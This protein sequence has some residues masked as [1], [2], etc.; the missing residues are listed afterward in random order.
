MTFYEE[1]APY[2]KQIFPLQKSQVAFVKRTFKQ[3]GETKLLEVGCGIGLLS[4]ALVSTQVKVAAFDLDEGMI[5]EAIKTIK[6]QVVPSEYLE[7]S[8]LNMLDIGKT[9]GNAAF[10]G[11]LCFGNTL[12]HLQSQENVLSFLKQAREVLKPYG[13]LLFQILN[14]ER[15]LNQKITTLPLIESDLISFERYYFYPSHSDTIDFKTILT[16]KKDNQKIEHTIPLLAL[17]RIDVETLLIQSGF[18]KYSFYGSYEMDP[19]TLD[20]DSLVVKADGK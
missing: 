7:F 18:E 17:R 3:F 4:F 10:D 6:R 8:K 16:I 19:F 12:V 13:V 14:Y 2:Y 1:I 5:K 9:F 11:I 20:S 15:I